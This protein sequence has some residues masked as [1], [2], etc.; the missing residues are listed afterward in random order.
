[1]ALGDAIMSASLS[2]NEIAVIDM[3]L[4][5]RKTLEKFSFDDI[6]FVLR[7]KPDAKFEKVK[8]LTTIEL[9]RP[10]VTDTLSIEQDLEVHLFIRSGQKT[11]A[12]FR[13]IV[14]T[15]LKTGEKICF[16][17][18]LMNTNAFTP[19]DIAQIY[20]ARWEIETFFKFLKQHFNLKHFM[21]HNANGIQV[22]L[23]VT[24]IAAMLIYV[25][26]KINEIESYKIDRKSTRLNSSHSR[27]SRMPSSA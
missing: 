15:M 16:L 5:A 7:I 23:Y 1:M 11:K 26:K 21:S 24:L 3:G 27:R 19:K 9:D 18:S 6:R 12:T 13:L 25:F 10:I 8:E 14:A 20:K 17:T 2:D 4:N 22:V